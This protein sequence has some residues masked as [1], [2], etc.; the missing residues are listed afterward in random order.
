MRDGIERDIPDILMLLYELGR[1]RPKAKSDEA[2]FEDLIRRYISD[3]GKRI[4]VAQN[5]DAKVVGVLS[6]MLLLRLNQRSLEMYVPEL[7]VHERFRGLNI[8]RLLVDRCIQIALQNGCHRI[9]LESGNQRTTSHKFYR[10]LG[11]EQSA[12]S[13]TL[14]LES[15]A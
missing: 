15:S 8:G 9:R 10:A 4:L 13:F 2:T 6:M 1:P 14:N 11:F 3:D 7:V 5:A 12:L